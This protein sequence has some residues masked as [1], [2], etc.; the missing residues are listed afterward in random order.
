MDHRKDAPSVD[1][2]IA[3]NAVKI[4]IVFVST[5]DISHF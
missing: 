3:M 4:Y 5:I 1:G 2:R